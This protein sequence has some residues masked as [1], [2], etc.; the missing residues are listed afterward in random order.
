VD[1]IFPAL[2]GL[3]FYFMYEAWQSH[4]NNT[5][6]HPVKKITAAI[7]GVSFTDTLDPTTAIS[8][9]TTV[10]AGSQVAGFNSLGNPIDSNGVAVPQ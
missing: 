8:S 3:G 9:V 1:A 4:T 7:K 5:T 10:P 2:I 6:P